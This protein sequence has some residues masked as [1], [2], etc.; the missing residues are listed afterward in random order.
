MS[1]IENRKKLVLSMKSK[2]SLKKISKIDKSL[3]SLI[4]T[5]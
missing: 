4:K 3:V 5:D 2:A 1:D